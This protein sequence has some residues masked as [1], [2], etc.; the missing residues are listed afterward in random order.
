[1]HFRGDPDENVTGQSYPWRLVCRRGEKINIWINSNS[2][3]ISVLL[4][5][6]R[7]ILEHAYWLSPMNNTAHINL[8]DLDAKTLPDLDH[9]NLVLQLKAKRLHLQTGSL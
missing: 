4:E 7:I 6:D 5:E 8:A 3:A 2:L 9:V 1:M